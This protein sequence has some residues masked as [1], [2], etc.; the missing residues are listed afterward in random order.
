MA[1]VCL[2]TILLL[3]CA[4][5]SAASPE[6]TQTEASTD[7]TT[8]SVSQEASAPGLDFDRAKLIEM[9]IENQKNSYAPYSGYHVSAAVLTDS[10][11]IYLGANVENASYPAGVCAEHNAIDV[12]VLS[13]E[14]KIVAI[15]IVGGADYKVSDYCAPCGICRQVMREFCDPMQMR[16][17]MA[18]SPTDYKEM[19]LEELLPEIFGPSNLGQ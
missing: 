19:T 14:R 3:L 8:G 12:A 13:G 1:G 2:T 6:K 17:I 11:E 7:T 9:A 4:S 10:G 5:C 15:A 18:V 16:V